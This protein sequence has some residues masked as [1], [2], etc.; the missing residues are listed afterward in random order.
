MTKYFNGSQAGSKEQNKDELQSVMTCNFQAT[1]H[2]AQKSVSYRVTTFTQALQ[3][4]TGVSV[5][6]KRGML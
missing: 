5:S 4:T 3:S 1:L 2:G 6:P